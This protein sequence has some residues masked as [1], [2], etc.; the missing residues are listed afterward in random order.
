MRSTQATV[1]ASEISRL[2][3]LHGFLV[4]GGDPIVRVTV[5]YQY[6]ALVR[7]PFVSVPQ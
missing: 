1:L 3:N 4:T 7:E 6:M 2:P 5:P